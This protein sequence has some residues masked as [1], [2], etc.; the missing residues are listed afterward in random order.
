VQHEIVVSVAVLAALVLL[1]VGLAVVFTARRVSLTRRGASFD[2]SV[3][4]PDGHWSLG[5]ARYGADHL[6]WFRIFSFSLRPREAW[7]RDALVVVER[8]LTAGAETT[9][10]LPQSVVVHCEHRGQRLDLAMSD[11]AYTGFA[12]WLESAPPGRHAHVT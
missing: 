8:R 3:R 2:C 5:I 7:Q 4:R 1:L 11:D 12:S 9:S 10:V 6:D